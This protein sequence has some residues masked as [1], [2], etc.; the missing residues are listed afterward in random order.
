[1]RQWPTKADLS[2]LLKRD[3]LDTVTG[4]CDRKKRSPHTGSHSSSCIR[5]RSICQQNS[6]LNKTNKNAKSNGAAT[7]KTYQKRGLEQILHF[8]SHNS[9]YESWREGF[10]MCNAWYENSGPVL[11]CTKKFHRCWDVRNEDTK[12]V[13]RQL[14]PGANHV[15]QLNT[16]PGDKKRRIFEVRF[17]G[18]KVRHR[19]YRVT[20]DANAM[21]TVGWGKDWPWLLLR[22]YRTCGLHGAGT[23]PRNCPPGLSACTFVRPFVMV[24]W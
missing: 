11:A 20:T 7:L 1:M 18:V 10:L 17:N 21:L 8:P 6:S 9:I 23:V 3:W 13:E 5:S 4:Q 14:F 16:W 22:R 24:D 2:L 15:T 12:L 19:P